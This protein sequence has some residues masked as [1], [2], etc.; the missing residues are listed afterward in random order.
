MSNKF[1]IPKIR[2]LIDH[3]AANTLIRELKSPESDRRRVAI[4][5]LP[6]TND[7]NSVKPL[8]E[9]LRKEKNE[10]IQR[11]IVDSLNDLLRTKKTAR[12]F[13]REGI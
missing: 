9:E 8:I 5:T 3:R 1:I 6:R 12:E 10:M 4:N 7:L 13:L 2:D 11:E